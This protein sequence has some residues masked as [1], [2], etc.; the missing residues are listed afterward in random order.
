MMCGNTGAFAGRATNPHAGGLGLL[1]D[2]LTWDGQ[3]QASCVGEN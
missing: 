1:L 3:W 2:L